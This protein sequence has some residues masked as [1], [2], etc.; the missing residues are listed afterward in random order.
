MC[1]VGDVAQAEG[2]VIKAKLV[3]S[4]KFNA[5]NGDDFSQKVYC[6]LLA[7]KDSW[8]IMPADPASLKGE[9]G[10]LDDT[11][12]PAAYKKAIEKLRGVGLIYVWEN[13]GAPWLYVMGHDEENQVTRRAQKP[14]IPRPDIDSMYAEVNKLLSES[15]VSQD[16]VSRPPAIQS[17]SQ[18]PIPNP[19]PDPYGFEEVWKA[20]PRKTKK[21]EARKIWEKM[22]PSPELRQTILSDLEKRKRSVDWMKNDGQYV[23][24]PTTYL[25]G[26]RW[27]DGLRVEI[28]DDGI[29]QGSP[30][31]MAFIR[32]VLNDK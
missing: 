29:P 30:E 25:N 3:R 32:R 23:P 17:L 16:S 14:R 7:C 5:L 24:H 2:W 22:K 28:E 19:N 12:K 21:K 27:T 31:N 9:L 18:S 26:E 10:P 11:K 20:Y 8:G 4:Q 1:E 6:L 13:Q 15:G